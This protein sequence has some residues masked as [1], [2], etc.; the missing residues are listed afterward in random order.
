MPRPGSVII[1]DVDA[2]K[3]DVF[4][5]LLADRELP[6]FCE[7]FS[8]GALVRYGVTVYPAETLPAQTSLFTGLE[9]RRHG[10]VGNG[11]MDRS[12]DPVRVLDF[13]YADTAA[14][15]FG[16]RLF[17]WPTLLLPVK[18]KEG[19]VNRELYTGAR[20]IYERA[21]AAG[22]SSTV[23]FN[24]VSRGCSNWIRPSRLDVIY[25]AL[26]TSGKVDFTRIDRQTYLSAEN[27]LKRNGI[28]DIFTLYFSGLDAWGH[29]TGSTGQ[30][31]YLKKAID[32]LITRLLKFLDK[33]GARGST[34][35]V[36]CSD[37]GQAWLRQVRMVDF[38]TLGHRL[39]ENGYT[40]FFGKRFREDANCYVSVIGGCAQ[41]Y[42]KNRAKNDWKLPPDT[43]RDLLPLAH[44]LDDISRGAPCPGAKQ[45]DGGMAAIILVRVSGEEGYRVFRRGELIDPEKFFWEKL[46]RYPHAFQNVYGLNCG[47]S[48]DIVMFTN[49][50]D[51]CYFSD[52]GYKRS[53]GGLAIEDT[54]IPIIF[55]GCGIKHRVIENA[56][57]LDIAPTILSFFGIDA[58]DM[59]GSALKVE[60]S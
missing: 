21:A 22:L 45:P 29:H 9:V 3:R 33:S 44:A 57:I 37:H 35:F 34:R 1:I 28:P 5:N 26:S 8:D 25:Y 48:G 51:G 58:N 14:G 54:G 47:R 55:A 30:A 15:V 46:D 41:F 18:D 10:I 17:G 2:L 12:A 42:V 60:A 31:E 36:L 43:S 13:G 40:L 27:S 32:P 19:S 6:G 39:A 23:I 16:Y 11:W 24:H 56:S 52:S 4:Y 49:F 53:H 7:M 50:E 59:D 20:T 38:A